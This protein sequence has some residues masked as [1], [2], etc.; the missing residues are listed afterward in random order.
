MSHIEKI[1]KL[2][3]KDIEDILGFYDKPD[4]NGAKMR[5]YIYISV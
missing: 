2:K 4:T 1:K 3:V 5:W